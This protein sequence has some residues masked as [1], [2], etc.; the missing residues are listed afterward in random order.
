MY[1]IVLEGYF[2]EEIMGLFNKK[3][4]V[5]I[6]Q[7]DLRDA[8]LS[9]VELG[10]S[11][12]KKRAFMDIL[13][14][15][16]AIKYL[17]SKKIE[18]NN[19]YS[20]YTI[21]SVLKE[22]DL[23]DIYYQGIRMDV[24]LVFNREEIFI[25][26]THYRYNL[27]PDIYLAFELQEDMSQA[28]FLGFFTPDSVDKLNEND[29][30]YFQQQENLQDPKEFKKFLKNFKPVMKLEPVNVNVEEAQELFIAMVDKELNN[31][32]LIYLLKQLS[33][34]FELREKL[35]EFENFELISEHI[36][37]EDSVLQD[38]MLSIV[39]AQKAFE[40]VEIEEESF[41]DIMNEEQDE[42]TE[43][44]D[45]VQDIDFDNTDE[46]NEDNQPQDENSDKND[47]IKAS[48]IANAGLGIA[49]VALGAAGIAGAAAAAS[50]SVNSLAAETAASIASNLVPDVNINL[51]ELK[52]NDENAIIDNIDVQ[53]SKEMEDMSKNKKEENVN[54]DIDFEQKNT[55][56][57]S[58]LEFEIVEDED[59]NPLGELPTLDFGG[60]NDDDVPAYMKELAS[61]LEEKDDTVSIDDLV[62]LTS[63]EDN[64]QKEPKK[65]EPTMAM[66]SQT[67]DDLLELDEPEILS[68]DDIA[69]INEEAANKKAV[70]KE[71]EIAVE[72]PSE[73]SDI[74]LPIAE[75]EPATK[76]LSREE[77][78]MQELNDLDDDFD[79]EP[80]TKE[81][82][83]N[84][85]VVTE[86]DSTN[87][88]DLDDSDDILSQVDSFLSNADL[89]NAD[90][91]GI[92]DL[93]LNS[94]LLLPQDEE[95]EDAKEDELPLVKNSDEEITVD[96]LL[97]QTSN[98]KDPLQIL[99]KDGK[100]DFEELFNNGK[101]ILEIVQKNK[102]MAIAASVA[103]VVLA[104]FAIGGMVS[105]NKAQKEL[106]TQNAE[107]E[108]LRKEQENM[109]NEENATLEMMQQN[110]E[111]MQNQVQ[112]QS[113]SGLSADMGQAV[114]N[115]FMSE[116]V[117]T[118]ITK[119]AWE[120][121][122]DLAY[123]DGFR[124]YLQMA[125]K[126]LKLNLQNDLL[127][128]SEMAYSNKV[129]VDLQIGK[130]GT[131]L[132]SNVVTSS[133][134][135]QIDKI[136]LQ[137]VKNTLKYLKMPADELGGRNAEVT[138]I[139]NF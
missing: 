111:N 43:N 81:P 117:S 71:E 51:P 123:N 119:V 84:E 36:V 50:Q 99:F 65:E 15:R 74:D 53:D 58:E 62:N 103:C 120:V 106:A 10:D 90:L 3:N 11:F 88:N 89:S 24:R 22:C 37:K 5:K 56:D 45:F 19:V 66:T 40:G 83:Q 48:D 18:A 59:E 55:E 80:E 87:T 132:S 128:V 113:Q 138:L 126:N 110:D 49:G 127:L 108:N 125:G 109:Y 134:S 79:V 139:I 23:S 70:E 13:G 105:S 93:D 133:N 96:D 35:V 42:D 8:K 102:K 6:E 136:V 115:A 76:E 14:A 64:S 95:K 77:K 118:N 122:E 30:F 41:D 131:L 33:A 16:L 67:E 39:G 28:E 137:S 91:S 54:S 86:Q 4:T 107:L 29:E 121:P 69:K 32:D 130:D 116:P 2:S 60:N 101:K 38:G 104:S 97:E 9:S 31:E 114:S 7:D 94:D 17:F 63:D 82:E 98:D 135:K 44:I 73:T 112:M 61:N 52:N 1:S 34:S 124:K 85:E 78:L 20:L 57:N 25:P 47:G 21:Q 46:N 12:T 92:E 68:L 27:T 75:D 26:K 72:Q 100:P 129:V